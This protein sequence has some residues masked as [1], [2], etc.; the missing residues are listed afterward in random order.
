MG[1]F[2]ATSVKR[3]IEDIDDDLYFLPA[4]QRQFVWEKLQITKLFDSIMQGFPI[5][6]FLFWEIDSTKK[7]QCRKFIREF[8]KEKKNF[9]TTPTPE[10]S[11]ARYVLD[12]QQRIS[13]LYIGLKGGSTRKKGKKEKRECLHLDLL[14]D[15]KKATGDDHE[16]TDDK[17]DEIQYRFKFIRL[18]QDGKKENQVKED[19]K[20][21]KEY[22]FPLS[23][24]FLKLSEFK[25]E[26]SKIKKDLEKH[27][28][29]ETRVELAEK[30]ADTL[31]DKVN[32]EKLINYFLIE[33]KENLDTAL[34]IFAR[35][36]MGGTKLSYANLLLSTMIA[37]GNKNTLKEIY[38]CVEDLNDIGI[39]YMAGKFNFDE[40][41]VLKACLVLSDVKDITFKTASFKPS[42]VEKMEQE[43][44][45]KTEA[46]EDAVHLVAEF[47]YNKRTLTANNVVIPIA[48]YIFLNKLSY[49]HFAKP[50]RKEDKQNILKWL[51]RSLI[52]QIFRGSTDSTLKSIQRVIKESEKDAFPYA[53]IR[54]KS[55]NSPRISL[56]IST[57]EVKNWLERTEY[58]DPP[59]FP[60]LS[61]LYKDEEVIGPGFHQDHIF[62]QSQ[63]KGKHTGFKYNKDHIANLQLLSKNEHKFKGPKDCS[64]WLKSL[65]GNERKKHCEKHYIPLKP[66]SQPYEFS[67]YDEFIEKRRE[68]MLKRL[69]KVLLDNEDPS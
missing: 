29:D 20:G 55:K 26:W 35:T 4:I 47:G 60:L 69:A 48:Y 68:L 34:Q 63:F 21:K 50:N 52:K 44:E 51:R 37:T 40:D 28:I 24:V 31:Y 58:K 43:W 38:T 23:N 64:E 57:Q 39:K 42:S 56:I 6:S 45:K 66:D 49:S 30:K 36:N 27:G 1:E 32:S 16:L 5:G 46:L 62:P 41:F 61:L 19:I 13:A 14:Y 2:K 15:P 3:I 7:Y 22:W 10:K 18:A 59:C 54:E 17:G 12:G 53:E 11:G 67:Q 25:S 65:D 8:D 9:E 33:K